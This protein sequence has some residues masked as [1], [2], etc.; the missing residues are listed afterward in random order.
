[1]K[2]RRVILA[3]GLISAALIAV[4]GDRSS[5]GEVVL[6][7]HA[8]PVPVLTGLRT[9]RQSTAS[10]TA[11]PAGVIPSRVLLLQDRALLTAHKIE[12]AS[13]APFAVLSWTP[14]PLPASTA[15][16]PSAP[17][18]PFKY[19][20]KEFDGD[21]WRIFLAREN[22]VLI[23]K[24]NDVIGDTYRIVSITPP[25]VSIVYLPLNETQQLGI[26]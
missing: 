1:M 6:P 17:P 12:K 5:P 26:E 24:A 16:T 7:S 23:V 3:G 14:P 21:Q 8:Q 15:V 2:M 18:L 20:G 4:F 22:E 13:A 11:D 9:E 10:D 25:T 19:L